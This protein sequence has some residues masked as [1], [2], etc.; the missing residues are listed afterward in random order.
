MGADTTDVGADTEDQHP[1]EVAPLSL[2][3]AGDRDIGDQGPGSASLRGAPYHESEDGGSDATGGDGEG[4]LVLLRRDPDERQTQRPKDDEGG[5]I[6][7]IHRPVGQRRVEV[8]ERRPQR[9]EERLGALAPPPDLRRVP[10]EREHDALHEREQRAVHAPRRLLQDGEADV[11][12]GPRRPR[13]HA[14]DAD[15]DVA[16]DNGEHGL[17][18]VEPESDDRGAGHPPADVEGAGDDPEA[19]ELPGTVGT[20]LQGQRPCV[21]VHVRFG[22]Y[23]CLSRNL[24]T[25]E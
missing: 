11:P 15:E 14:D 20:S 21:T 25:L 9:S 6:P 12:L 19:H 24:E 17:P 13:K 8:P 2:L 5:E 22:L 16:D 7:R 1:P 10:D 23:V 3:N 4:N 18:D